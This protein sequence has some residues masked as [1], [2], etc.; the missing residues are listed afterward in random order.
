MELVDKVL[1]MDADTVLQR[2]PIPWLL[3]PQPYKPCAKFL[4]DDVTFP[5]GYHQGGLAARVLLHWPQVLCFDQSRASDHTS[6]VQPSHGSRATGR[7]VLADLQMMDDSRWDSAGPGNTGFVFIRSSCRTRYLMQ[8]VQASLR[9]L[10]AS[11]AR[12]CVISGRHL[13]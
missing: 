4:P 5:S 6:D 11:Q 2:D 13:P 7:K 9:L 12:H 8:A 3:A 10:L 1:W